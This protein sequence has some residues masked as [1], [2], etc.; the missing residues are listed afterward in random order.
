MA[1]MNS[2]IKTMSSA[3]GSGLK[4]IAAATPF[5][6]LLVSLINDAASNAH[7]RAEQRANEILVDRLE[8]LEGRVDKERITTD[9]FVDL[10]KNCWVVQQRSLYDEKLR[11]AANIIANALLKDGD[12]D[13]LTYDELD[14]FTRCLEHLSIGAIHILTKAINYADKKNR[15]LNSY[16]VDRNN[17]R[18]DFGELQSLAPE[19]DANLLMGL[20]GELASF[21]LLHSL[22]SPT[23]RYDGKQ[24]YS[25]YPF[26]TTPLGYRFVQHVLSPPSV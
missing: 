26:E 4:A 21:H 18:V 25:N 9:E 17:I 22:G 23:A 15:G 16:K 7:E 11:G 24:I 8:E 5:G 14:H 10:Y 19:I 1:N 20:L 13:R 3:A 2:T 12:G 6:S